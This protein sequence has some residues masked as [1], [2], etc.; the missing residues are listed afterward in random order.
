MQDIKRNPLQKLSLLKQKEI[1]INDKKYENHSEKSQEYEKELKCEYIS[2]VF[3]ETMDLSQMVFDICG[4]ESTE[5]FR[6]MGSHSTNKQDDVNNLEIFH[7]IDD[8]IDV[9]DNDV[10]INS[11]SN[12]EFP[13]DESKKSQESEDL[14]I[15]HCKF[16]LGESSDD[17]NS[18]SKQKKDFN[19]RKSK[20]NS[21][22]TLNN[23][24]VRSQ[25][26]RQ[27][28]RRSYARSTVG[29]DSEWDRNVFGIEKILGDEEFVNDNYLSIEECI[30]DLTDAFIICREP[31]SF[32]PQSEFKISK[33]DNSINEI[34]DMFNF[35]VKDLR[36]IDNPDSN[37]LCTYIVTKN[38]IEY[39][40]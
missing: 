6:D 10:D 5:S 32:T 35:L 29:F 36:W 11:S 14:S 27:S 33:E 12:N 37:V 28:S 1:D 25:V 7:S 18:K 16:S 8:I 19:D 17:N 21:A 15:E 13:I 24:E 22:I 9:I 20:R 40:I 4:K 34:L 23:I 31:E 30:D 39:K 26:S 38:R 3:H 2:E